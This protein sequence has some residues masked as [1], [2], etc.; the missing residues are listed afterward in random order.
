V[1]TEVKAMKKVLVVVLPLFLALLVGVGGA[2]GGE[3]AGTRA[4][5]AAK[6]AEPAPGG[7]TKKP[8]VVVKVG[9]VRLFKKA[10]R[11]EVDGHFCYEDNPLE[12][13]AV[14]KGGKEYESLLCFDCKA[15]DV[16][17]LLMAAG[18]LASG[19]VRKK[20]DPNTPKGDPVYLSLRWKD[21]EGK[22]KTIRAEDL[23][24]N[25]ATKKP[26]R[27]TAWVFTGSSFI[28]VKDPET[29]KTKYRFLA[30]EYKM[31]I[32][33]WRDPAAIFNNP[34]D[35]G[36]DDVFYVVNKKVIPKPVKYFCPRHTE[37]TSKKPGKCHKCE[38][39]T[40]LVPQG[41]PVTLIMDPAPK[42]ALKPENLKDGAHLIKNI[43][44]DKP[45]TSTKGGAGPKGGPE[46]K[47]A[48]KGGEKK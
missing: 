28:K 22:S 1:K 42:D 5:A 26:M 47:K 30:D 44:D 7:D 16:N 15:S 21:D 10:R 14:I 48:P 37:V 6:G 18:Y 34:L 4:L 2:E 31:L 9:K 17:F 36:G 25:R 40:P 3:A 35:T 43:V 12:F 20:G 29:G 13:L 23:L 11:V 24:F 38:V 41:R 39:G 19:G 33:I 46:E 32:A 45:P 27:K 8:P